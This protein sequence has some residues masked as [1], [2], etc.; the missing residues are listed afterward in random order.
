M[1]NCCVYCTLNNRWTLCLQI[2]VDG[3]CTWVGTEGWLLEY[4]EKC[5]V[6]SFRGMSCLSPHIL[7]IHYKGTDVNL[8]TGNILSSLKIGFGII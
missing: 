5:P 7:Y 6:E 2:T 4:V 8:I 1:C 3:V